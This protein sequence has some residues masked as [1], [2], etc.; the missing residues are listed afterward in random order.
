MPLDTQA[1][2]RPFQQNT[3]LLHSDWTVQ[4]RQAMLSSR[5]H[6]EE[7][8]KGRV[9]LLGDAAW[10]LTFLSGQGTSTALAGAY[11]LAS[12][13]A[14]KPYPQA[15]VAYERRLR[16]LTVRMQAASRR[17]GGHYVPESRFGMRLQSWL[18]PLLLKR[19]FAWLLARRIMAGELDLGPA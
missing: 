10:C 14:A 17:I 7:A 8:T 2:T 12:E 11:I 4:P 13:L 19:P 1:S 16:P 15:F 18:L 5:H 6:H 9:V 3:G